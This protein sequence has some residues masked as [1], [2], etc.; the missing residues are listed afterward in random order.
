VGNFYANYLTMRLSRNELA[1]FKG[2]ARQAIDNGSKAIVLID[3]RPFSLPED[4]VVAYDQ[5]GRAVPP[6][7]LGCLSG[8]CLQSGAILHVA[9]AELGH[10]M[11]V[12]DVHPIRHDEPTPGITCERLTAATPSY[13]GLSERTISL[14]RFLRSQAPIT[15]VTYSLAWRNLELGG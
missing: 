4:I 10:R 14:V 13:R 2:I 9:A 1:Y 11:D 7:E 3:P 6:Y 5:T 8:V 15:C 12:F